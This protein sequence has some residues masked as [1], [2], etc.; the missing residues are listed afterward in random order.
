[1]P[2]ANKKETKQIYL[3]VHNSAS[4]MVTVHTEV[5]FKP[6]S[7]LLVNKANL[8]DQFETIEKSEFPTMHLSTE[9][10]AL[11]EFKRR[12]LN[13]K[14]QFLPNKILYLKTILFISIFALCN[15]FGG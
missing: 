1:M 4:K 9:I 15:F 11:E 8:C 12:I 14:S 2:E 10:T 5:I 3:K 6:R 7:F 13:I